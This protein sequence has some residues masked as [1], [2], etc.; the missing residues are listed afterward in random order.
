MDC[1]LLICNMYGETFF[2][3]Q[4]IHMLVHYSVILYDFTFRLTVTLQNFLVK[5]EGSV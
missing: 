1:G 3:T 4:L 2:E 5:R